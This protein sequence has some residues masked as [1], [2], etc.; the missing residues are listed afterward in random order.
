MII[1]GGLNLLDIANTEGSEQSLIDRG[2]LNRLSVV[3]G[4]SS[5]VNWL[6]TGSL[7]IAFKLGCAS[8]SRS[9]VA[10]VLL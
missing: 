3:N 7:L 2:V 6:N 5:L 10:L 9:S 1:R 8:R 4:L